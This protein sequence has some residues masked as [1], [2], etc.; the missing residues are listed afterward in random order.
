[1]LHGC[2]CCTSV[3]LPALAVASGE[4]PAAA[5]ADAASV[6]EI[7]TGTLHE[8]PKRPLYVGLCYEQDVF[9]EEVAR[10]VEAATRREIAK[11]QTD[12]KLVQGQKLALEQ[13]VEFVHQDQKADLLWILF[14]VKADRVD[15]EQLAQWMSHQNVPA[16][17]G[18]TH[19]VL[20]FLRVVS[21]IPTIQFT[22]AVTGEQIEEL[23]PTYGKINNGLSVFVTQA[24]PDTEM[25][26]SQSSM[27]AVNRLAIAIFAVALETATA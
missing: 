10:W 12:E 14:P 13:G 8:P 1:M 20:C 27:G 22:K 6:T 18:A 21:A 24:L 5:A 9:T 17:Q 4:V 23:T 25:V 19:K 15:T 26:V 3:K 16:D 7:D 2:A 11:K